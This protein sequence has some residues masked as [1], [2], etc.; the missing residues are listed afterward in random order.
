M[1]GKFGIEQHAFYLYQLQC[2]ATKDCSFFFL[3]FCIA[4]ISSSFSRALLGCSNLNAFLV[5]QSIISNS[6][7]SHQTLLPNFSNG[8]DHVSVWLS[9]NN[10]R[11]FLPLLQLFQCSGLAKM[12]L[13]LQTRCISTSC[14]PENSFVLRSTLFK[15]LERRFYRNFKFLARAIVR[16]Y[17]LT[18]RSFWSRA[19][20]VAFS[21]ASGLSTL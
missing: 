18:V 20:F 19:L 11:S 1:Q 15:K 5:P 9:Q 8:A 12:L 21:P 10:A 17:R 4:K 2:F 14:G 3:Y 13:I 6:H 7:V 16:R